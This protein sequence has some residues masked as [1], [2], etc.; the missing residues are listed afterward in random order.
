MGDTR[1]TRGA[2]D[3]APGDGDAAPGRALPMGDPQ[4]NRAL[5]DR[6]AV[7]FA[8]SR[9]APWDPVVAFLGPLPVGARVLDLAG[10]GGRHS[11]VAAGMGHRPVLVDV[12]GALVRIARDQASAAGSPLA[13]VEADA[14]RLPL[15]TGALDAALFIAGVHCIRGR[16]RRV[17]AL[18]ELCRVLRPGA[19]ALVTV[20]SAEQDRF[21]ETVGRRRV[22]AQKD[23]LPQ[24]EEP[25][26]VRVPWSRDVD[27]PVARF[28]HVYFATELQEELEE[29]GL[30]VDRI[31]GVTLTRS[32]RPD[33]WFA[34]VR[35]P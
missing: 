26:D 29:A 17:R 6:I 9:S 13:A 15:Q 23:R 25:G 24:G 12:S 3:G 10:G 28:F 8:A 2:E 16:H 35:A 4:T 32:S 27:E 1:G 20:W 33:N 22:A 7:P 34:Y 31:D 11:L 5:M 19:P 30:Q 18:S 14:E 21:R